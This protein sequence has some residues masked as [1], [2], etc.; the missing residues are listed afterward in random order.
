MLSHR[1]TARGLFLLTLLAC[2]V[3]AGPAAARPEALG[4][5]VPQL[6]F[7]V[8]G[9]ATYGNDF[10]DPRGQGSHEGIDIMAAKRST[11]VAAEPGRVKFHTTSARAGC[12]L[13]LDGASG[14]QYLYVHLN[15]DL[16]KGNDNTG[17]CIAGV[18]YARG[19]KNGDKVEA[20]QP[21]AYVGDSGDADGISAHLHFEVHPNGGA[22]ANPYGHLQRAR[23]L[24]LAVT[25]GK[26]FTAALRGSVVDAY[27]DG[28]LEGSL[29]LDVEQVTSWP[30][31]IRVKG[32][33]RSVQLRV[34]LE[35]LI[36]NPVGALIEAARLSALQPG[37]AAVAWTTKTTATLAAALGEP[38]KLATDRVELGF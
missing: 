34:P 14:T 3:A 7:P 9:E 6:I 38:F 29:T 5:K 13:Y 12:M 31:S 24:L 20:G 10:G 33:K 32:V 28:E 27:G 22:A 2:G 1:T 37:Q 35:T 30:G 21:I 4:G 19:L 8:V 18:S 15:N 25:P 17:K 26:P 11:A 16:T 23:R 36:F